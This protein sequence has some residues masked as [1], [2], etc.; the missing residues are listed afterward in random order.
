MADKL[1]T[2]MNAIAKTPTPRSGSG[3]FGGETGEGFGK[4]MQT[5][6]ANVIP[7]KTRDGLKGKAGNDLAS[8]F[9]GA[10]K[11]GKQVG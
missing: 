1:E 11:K 2:T 6:G 10:F 3:E 7:I 9:I 5:K 4:H 8:P